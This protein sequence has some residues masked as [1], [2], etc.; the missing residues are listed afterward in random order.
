MD[1]ILLE[2]MYE[3]ESQWVDYDQDEYVLKLDLANQLAQHLIDNNIDQAIADFAPNSWTDTGRFSVYF[4][5]VCQP[6]RGEILVTRNQMFSRKA[7]NIVNFR[8]WDGWLIF[9]S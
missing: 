1:E 4:K 5:Q 3:E 8:M 7:K 9:S 2:E 6:L